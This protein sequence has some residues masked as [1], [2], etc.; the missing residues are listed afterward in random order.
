MET[1]PP[2]YRSLAVCLIADQRFCRLT[3]YLFSEFWGALLEPRVTAMEHRQR[4]AEAVSFQGGYRSTPRP[5]RTQ[6]E[7][8]RH[9]LLNEPCGLYVLPSP[10]CLLACIQRVEWLV[11]QT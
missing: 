4:H 3:L 11:D 6:A 9:F 2:L 7:D 10:A 1:D 5:S 8:A